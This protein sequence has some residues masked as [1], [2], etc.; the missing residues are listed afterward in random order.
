MYGVPGK[1]V[2]PFPQPPLLLSSPTLPPPRELSWKLPDSLKDEAVSASRAFQQAC[3][4]YTLDYVEF[5]EF[6]KNACKVKSPGRAALPSPPNE[7]YLEPTS[8]SVVQRCLD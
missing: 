7:I 1:G 2:K 5:R 8:S 6:G 4:G 3:E